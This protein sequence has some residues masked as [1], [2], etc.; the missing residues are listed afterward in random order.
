MSNAKGNDF[1]SIVAQI[2]NPLNEFFVKKAPTLPTNIKDILVA[3]IPWFTLIGVIIS[4]PLL[5]AALGLSAFLPLMGK[6]SA[7]STNILV[8]I[9]LFITVI[10]NAFALPGLFNKQRRGWEF[11]FYAELIG[12]IGTI[13]SLNLGGI[14]GTILSFYILFQVREYYK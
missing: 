9:V 1:K 3:I 5:L 11:L 4:I 14:L 12:V 13:L 10:L 7:G 2:E 6:Y 8:I